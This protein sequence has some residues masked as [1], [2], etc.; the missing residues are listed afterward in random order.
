MVVQTYDSASRVT[1]NAGVL[2]NDS[3]IVAPAVKTLSA[4]Q[5]EKFVKECSDQLKKEKTLQIVTHPVNYSDGNNLNELIARIME[6][7]IAKGRIA[8]GFISESMQGDNNEK[9]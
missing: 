7:K 3:F 8:Y 5:I 6:L 1:E 9:K 4:G 2:V